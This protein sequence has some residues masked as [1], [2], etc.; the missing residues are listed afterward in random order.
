LARADE[1]L[2]ADKRTSK[3]LAGSQQ[4]KSAQVTVAS[5]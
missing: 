5:S 2:Y 3:L 1:E 4:P